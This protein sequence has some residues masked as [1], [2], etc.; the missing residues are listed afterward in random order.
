MEFKAILSRITVISLS[1]AACVIVG[2]FILWLAHFFVP[3]VAQGTPPNYFQVISA[4]L[5][6]ENRQYPRGQPLD[7]VGKWLGVCSPDP[8]PANPSPKAEIIYS[9]LKNLIFRMESD[10]T[11]SSAFIESYQSSSRMFQVV[12]VL[13]T[14]ATAIAAAARASEIKGLTDRYGSSLNLLAIVLPIIATA[15]ATLNP[16]FVQTEASTRRT[17]MNTGIIKIASDAGE[18]LITT[19]CIE[20]GN[21]AEFAK[22]LSGWNA[23]YAQIL[24][25]TMSAQSDSGG[26][27][28]QEA[29]E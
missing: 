13:L 17:K 4:S 19:G 28:K 16:V 10:Q 24:I 11:T 6:S 22:R 5:F 3:P 26:N 2:Y 18:Y 25:D 1:L 20:T 8:G 14:M 23:Q 9:D 7:T 21:E 15:V 27:S 29:A 12:T